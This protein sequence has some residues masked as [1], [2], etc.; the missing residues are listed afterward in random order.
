MKKRPLVVFT[1]V[2]ALGIITAR[3]IRIPF[4]FAYLAAT[5]LL[6]LSLL[7]LKRSF[8]FN[9]AVLG[10]IFCLGTLSLINAKIL[11]NCHIRKYVYAKNISLPRIKGFVDRQPNTK[12]NRT[13]FILRTEEIQFHN[14]KRHCCG[15]ILVSVKGREDLKYGEALIVSGNLRRPYKNYL[16]NQG[17][18]VLLHTR[19]PHAVV[20]L[21]KNRGW[22]MKRLSLW[23]KDKMEAIIFKYIPAVP[24]SI[25]DAMILGERKD[26][27]ASI[28]RAMVLSGTVHI[29]VVSGFNVGLVA[30]MTNLLLSLL[31]VAKKIRFFIASP[32]LIIYCLATGASTPVIRATVMAI[33]F[34]SA[35]FLKREA[36]I[37]NSCAISAICILGIN[38]R[39]LFDIGFQLSFLS[40]LSIVYFYP[41][42]GAFLRTDRLKNR[43]VKFLIDGILVSFSAWVGTAGLIAHY[44]K[45][46]SLVTVLAN[47]LIVPLATLIT[48]CGFSLIIIGLIVP[49]LAPLFSSTSQLLV[50]LLLNLNTLLIKI[51]GAYFYLP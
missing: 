45:I 47:L 44:F 12:F 25:L 27:P 4:V 36:D 5:A 42:L 23:L 15:D 50:S 19:P 14:L 22:P 18:Y 2:F 11:P 39:Q 6:I 31:R 46:I 20:R 9:S 32:V 21:N 43:W 49:A 38:P 26:I 3:V 34:M 17:I 10:L 28:G 41:R 7:S 30:L 51:P 29:L 35:Y 48:F 8:I 1:L 37:Y 33:V 24:A 40:V 13:S 16:A